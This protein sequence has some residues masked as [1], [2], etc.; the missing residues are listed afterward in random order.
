MRQH[1]E[2]ADSCIGAHQRRRKEGSHDGR[3]NLGQ[4]H[5]RGGTRHPQGHCIVQHAGVV[6]CVGPSATDFDPKTPRCHI[7]TVG[8]NGRLYE[9]RESQCHGG[10]GSMNRT[11]LESCIWDRSFAGSGLGSSLLY[12]EERVKHNVKEHMH[13]EGR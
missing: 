2:I 9:G 11:A 3:W 8:I 13:Y 7:Y 1:L 5:R 10:A 6:D 4:G 12:L